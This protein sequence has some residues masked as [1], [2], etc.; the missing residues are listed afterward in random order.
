[1]KQD[2]LIDYAMPLMNIERLAKK[3][4][5]HCLE[6]QYEK[7]RDVASEI[8]GETRVLQAVLGLMQKGVR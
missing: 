1:M 3:I 4:H 2:D 7:A 6:R 5:D 8:I